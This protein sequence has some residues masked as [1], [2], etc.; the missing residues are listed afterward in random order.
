M[1]KGKTLELNSLSSQLV[2]LIF[3]DASQSGGPRISLVNGVWVEKS[4][5]LKP[6]FEE[7]ANK[8]YKTEA[9]PHLKNSQVSMG[10][11]KY[12]VVFK[13]RR[14]GIYYTWPNYHEQVDKFN[15]ACYHSYG[16]LAEAQ[17]QLATYL[18][19]AKY[20]SRERVEEEQRVVKM[21]NERAEA[22]PQAATSMVPWVSLFLVGSIILLLKYAS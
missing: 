13:G 2:A 17:S 14:P 11:Q 12:Y 6:S 18:E 5:P 3:T 16:T 19:R 7:T 4:L 9:K 10:K 8:L 22:V 21:P 1:S 20:W 15:G